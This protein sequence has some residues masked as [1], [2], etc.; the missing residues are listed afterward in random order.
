LKTPFPAHISII[1]ADFG[2][3]LPSYQ[4]AGIVAPVSMANYPEAEA[5]IDEIFSFSYTIYRQIAEGRHE[6]FHQGAI[7]L[8]A[9]FPHRE[10]SR[11]E[12]YVKRGVMGPAKDVWLDFGTGTRRRMVA[13]DDAIMV[14][15]VDGGQRSVGI[16]DVLRNWLQSTGR[17]HF[18]E[19]HLTDLTSP[20]T[21][22]IFN[23]TG[24]GARELCQDERLVSVQGHLLLLRDQC[25][26]EMQYMLFSGMTDD[27]TACGVKCQ[28]ELY[29][30]PKYFPETGEMGIVGGTFIANCGWGEPNEEQFECALRRA[31]D[32][33]GLEGGCDKGLED[34]RNGVS[35]L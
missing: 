28:T 15:A 7:F 30:M 32:F 34:S 24:L 16:M 6:D 2:R 33:Y 10:E 11:M 17:V 9:F 29:Q 4:A 19:R 23:C 25:P 1:A 20:P 31:R 12:C 18:I 26:E 21:K 3:S 35:K 22:F 14:G 5:F 27:R 8:P 13:Y